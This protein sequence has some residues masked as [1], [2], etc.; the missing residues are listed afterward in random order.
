MKDWPV[1][2]HQDIY[3]M[4]RKEPTATWTSRRAGQ[5]NGKTE[6]EIR[7]IYFGSQMIVKAKEIK[8]YHS[9]YMTP[10]FIPEHELDSG[11]QMGDMYFALLKSILWAVECHIKATKAVARLANVTGTSYIVFVGND[12]VIML[13]ISIFR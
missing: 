1:P 10:S 13:S 6:H 4:R 12:C 2:V 9:K 7:E 3:K 11:M 5:L 8:A